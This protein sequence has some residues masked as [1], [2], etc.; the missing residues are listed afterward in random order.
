VHDG[1]ARIV[2]EMEVVNDEYNWYFF[3]ECLKQLLK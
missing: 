1:Q 3:G 2:R